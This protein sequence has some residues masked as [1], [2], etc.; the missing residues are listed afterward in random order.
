M[1]QWNEIYKDDAMNFF[2]ND[3]QVI[4][5]DGTINYLSIYH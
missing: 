2:L 4:C 5:T 1:A 3:V